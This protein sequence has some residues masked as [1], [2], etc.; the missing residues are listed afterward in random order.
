MDFLYYYVIY[1]LQLIINKCTLILSG[2]HSCGYWL[3]FIIEFNINVK[4]ITVYFCF[5]ET[6]RFLSTNDQTTVGLTY[7]SSLFSCFRDEF[8]NL[9]CRHYCCC[10]LRTVRIVS[11]VPTTTTVLEWHRWSVLITLDLPIRPYS[12]SH[13]P[14]LSPFSCH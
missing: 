8:G 14:L 2:Q 10:I 3:F 12:D 6:E 9:D 1:V 13:I 7:Q 5:R 11:D 4:F